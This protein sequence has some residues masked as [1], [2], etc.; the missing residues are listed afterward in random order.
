MESRGEMLDKERRDADCEK[1]LVASASRRIT[2]VEVHTIPVV[3]TSG[4]S[5]GTV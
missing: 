4:A 3:S 2:T 5:V 1:S